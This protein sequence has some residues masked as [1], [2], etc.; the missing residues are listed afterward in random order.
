MNTKICF[1]CKKEK[2]LT[3]FYIRKDGWIHSYCKICNTI[4]KQKWAKNNLDKIRKNTQNFCA[5]NPIRAFLIDLKSRSKRK[6]I[7]FNLEECDIC[8]PDYC[9]ALNIKLNKQKHN[10]SNKNDDLPELDRIVPQKG[11]IKGNVKII[12]RRANRLK[13]DGN[14]LEHE[15]IVQYLR[16]NHEFFIEYYI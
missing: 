11:Y 3:D 2:S 16:D 10:K 8:V 15:K 9:P 4:E 14:L 1:A 13:N 6:N 5:N 12:S 7:P